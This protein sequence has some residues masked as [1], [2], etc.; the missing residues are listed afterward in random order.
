MFAGL[1]L[2]AKASFACAYSGVAWGL[3][4]IPLRFVNENGFPGAWS[5]TLYFV[6]SAVLLLSV[7]ACD[8]AADAPPPPPRTTG[9]NR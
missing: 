1:S 8:S 5:T 3:F 9:A 4:W 7:R 6:V 2:K